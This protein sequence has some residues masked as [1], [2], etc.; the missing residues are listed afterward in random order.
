MCWNR[1]RSLRKYARQC[2]NI[3]ICSLSYLPMSM[4]HNISLVVLAPCE[5]VVCLHTCVCIGGWSTHQL[6]IIHVLYFL[7]VG[8]H[9]YIYIPGGDERSNFPDVRNRVASTGNCEL[10]S[11]S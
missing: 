3:C 8:S 10:L 1:G 11:S 9:T 7:L 6:H 4:V 5:V 2:G